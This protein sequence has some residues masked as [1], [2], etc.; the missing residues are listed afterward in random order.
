[1]EFKTDEHGQVSMDLGAITQ[2]RIEQPKIRKKPE[3][4]KKPE[5]RR[6]ICPH[7]MEMQ[8]IIQL[9]KGEKYCEERCGRPDTI[10]YDIMNYCVDCTWIRRKVN[11]Y[12]SEAA[13]RNG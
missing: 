6:V 9:V 5:S 7:G 4:E 11:G 12:G 13:A 8:S 10:P 2:K 3:P 1:M